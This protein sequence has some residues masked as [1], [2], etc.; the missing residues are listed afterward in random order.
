MEESFLLTPSDRD[1]DTFLS[2]KAVIAA[3]TFTGS[4][5]RKFEQKA[6]PTSEILITI[7]M[8]ER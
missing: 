6:K 3:A 7:T 4:L 2:G 5:L 8:E 1:A